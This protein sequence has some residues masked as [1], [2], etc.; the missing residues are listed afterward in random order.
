MFR[1][2][3]GFCPFRARVIGGDFSQGVALCYELLPRW[4]V[5]VLPMCSGA[6]VVGLR[7]RNRPAVGYPP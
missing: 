2:Y 1:S 5:L 3:F 7:R 6:P 4:G